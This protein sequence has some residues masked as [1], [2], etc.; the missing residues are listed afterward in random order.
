MGSQFVDFNADGVTDIFTA[1]YDGSVHVAYGQSAA[2]DHMTPKGYADPVHVLDQNGQRVGLEMMWYVDKKSW[3]SVFKLQCITAVAFDWDADGDLDI[4]MGCYN[5]G[6]VYLRYNDGKAD[7]PAFRTTNEMVL[8]GGEPF[9]L[10]GGVTALRLVDWDGDGLTD[11]VSGSFGAKDR[12]VLGGVYLYRNA[13]KRGAPEFASAEALIPPVTEPDG[14][15]PSRGLYADPV[16][17]D[18]DGDLDL[19]VGGYAETK[20]ETTDGYRGKPGIWLYKRR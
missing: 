17:Y 9:A 5:T 15:G 18:G 6:N 20:S 7:A 2:A 3:T 12:S 19:L 14:S 10:A 11:L 13:G 16:D 8:A 1:T 4:L